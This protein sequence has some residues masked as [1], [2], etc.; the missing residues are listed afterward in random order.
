[1]LY[2]W[3][4]SEDAS[5]DEGMD[6]YI[7]KRYVI[8]QSVTQIH[9]ELKALGVRQ[10]KTS[11]DISEVIREHHIEDKV[12]EKCAKLLQMRNVASVNMQYN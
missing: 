12:I 11:T 6:V 2:A 5:I 10:F 7:F 3:Q 9:T 1:M 4:K 8:L